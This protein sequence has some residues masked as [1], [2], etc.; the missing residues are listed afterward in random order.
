MVVNYVQEGEE[1]VNDVQDNKE[2]D[3]SED[4]DYVTEDEDKNVEKEGDENEGVELDNE[5]EDIF[6]SPIEGE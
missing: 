6:L 2:R 3:M 5:K 4:T 1:G